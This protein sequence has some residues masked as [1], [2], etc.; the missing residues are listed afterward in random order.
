MTVYK[1]GDG[2]TLI[3]AGRV[4]ISIHEGSKTITVEVVYGFTKNSFTYNK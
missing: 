3:K 1:N 4:S 2:H